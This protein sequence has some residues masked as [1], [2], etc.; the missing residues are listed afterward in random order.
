M[1]S[2]PPPR[3]IALAEL[4]KGDAGH[5]RAQNAGG[6]DLLEPKHDQPDRAA[7]T[8]TAIQPAPALR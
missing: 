1:F 7:S 3:H 8:A 2:L 5:C 4:A 6:R